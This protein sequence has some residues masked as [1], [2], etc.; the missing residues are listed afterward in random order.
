ML[1]ASVGGLLVI[2]NLRTLLN[3][4]EVSVDLRALSYAVVAVVWVAAVAVSYA[5]HRAEQQAIVA[6][7]RV[8]TSS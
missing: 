7:R 3:A 8:P 6:E 4:F 5:K 2:T 1:G